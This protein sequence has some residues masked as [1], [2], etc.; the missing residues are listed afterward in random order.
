MV[1]AVPKTI[2]DVS[3]LFQIKHRKSKADFF[4]KSECLNFQLYEI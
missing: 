2:V 1:N 4:V 3:A